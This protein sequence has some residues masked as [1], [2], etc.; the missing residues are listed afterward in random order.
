MSETV[1]MPRTPRS[2]GEL[3]K[4]STD[5]R[6]EVWMIE[7][8]AKMLSSGGLGTGP[9]HNASLESFIIHVRAVMEF[10][11]EKPIRDDDV[12]GGDFFS[13]ESDWDGLRPQ[14]TDTLCRA[15]NR[16]GKELAHLTYGRLKVTPEDKPWPFMEIASD[17]SSAM[18]VF[19]K[20]V[21]KEKL[22]DLWSQ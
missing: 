9:L 15:K 6:Y 17:I 3:Q 21:P 8:M 22:D 13:N 16:V 10:L 12:V 20:H 1:E 11:Y 19:L 14:R 18:D 7:S 2:V 5:L 4:I